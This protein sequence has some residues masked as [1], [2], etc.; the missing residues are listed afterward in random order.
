[1]VNVDE[2]AE[3]CDLVTCEQDS[4][5]LLCEQFVRTCVRVC[6]CLKEKKHG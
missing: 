2:Q 5:G 3:C 4:V 1:M 6:D